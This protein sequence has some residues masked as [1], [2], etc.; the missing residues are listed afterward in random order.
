MMPLPKSTSLKASA[1]QHPGLALDKY[2]LSWNPDLGES[3]FQE[4]IQKPT[5]EA[6]VRLSQKASEEGFFKD[7][8]TRRKKML[9]ALSAR[10]FCGK[11]SGP[12]TLHLSR[13]SSLENAGICLHPLYGFAYLPG[14]GLKGL[15]RAFAETVW[16][17]SKPA[18]RE[19]EAKALIESVF[20]CISKGAARAGSV[21]FYDAW[22][23][24]W[25][26]LEVDIVN[27]HHG[28]YYDG[29]D[30]PGDWEDP[31]PVYFLSIRTGASFSFAIGGRRRDTKPEHLAFATDWLKGGLSLLGAGAKTN[32][33]YGTIVNEGADQAALSS[34]LQPACDVAVELLTPAF[35]A[36]ASQNQSDCD[37]RPATLRGLLRWWW[38]TMHA[39]HLSRADLLRLESAIWGDTKAGGAVRLTVERKN[40]RSP[41]RYDFKSG[42]GPKTE[43]KK[44]NELQDSPDRK[45]S[46]GLFYL[47]YG[48]DDAGRKRWYAPPES[49]WTISL[50]ARETKKNLLIP[51]DLILEQAKSALW[52][53][54]HYGGMGAKCRKGFGSLRIQAGLAGITL[55]SLKKTA[56]DLRK[57]TGLPIAVLNEPKSPSI[58]IAIMQSVPTPWSNYWYALD[59]LGF[60]VQTFAKRYKHNVEKRALGLPRKIGAP[61]TGNFHAP[62]GNRHASP[63]HFHFKRSA[64]GKLILEIIAFPSAYL[65]D[66]KRNQDFI[67]EFAEYLLN[68][69]KNRSSIPG[70]GTQPVALTLEASASV[71]QA[72]PH[73]TIGLPKA[74][75]LVEVILLEEKTKKG[76]WKA[77]HEPTGLSGPIQNHTLVPSEKKAGDSITLMVASINTRREIQFKVPAE[78]DISSPRKSGQP[79]GGK[80]KSFSK[81]GSSSRSL[82]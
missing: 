27:N 47:S 67:L 1:N 26:P 57:H 51:A 49:A 53:L 52:L 35:L 43:F 41:V 65:P 74:S 81:K 59:Q 58:D 82:R 42:Y 77:R 63:V 36:G 16:L 12:L 69:I 60:V 61:M 10:L 25:A 13:A 15:A 34:P 39:G 64:D 62:K 73:A 75:D 17:K 44:A 78:G 14:S 30:D 5:L 55:G 71:S 9:S 76:G 33:G 29:K 20:G 79:S 2:A 68:E 3:K 70:K 24:F 4:K 11:N 7:L 46:Q 18:D 40:S 22:P 48:M 72:S 31:V 6:V 54:C 32:A 66:F 56:A 50:S 38:R 23:E 8:C 21:V 45:T 19:D 28:G 80:G 37:L